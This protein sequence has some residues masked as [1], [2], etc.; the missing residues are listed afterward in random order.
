MKLLKGEIMVLKRLFQLSMVLFL[1]TGLASYSLAAFKTSRV[2]NTKGLVSTPVADL[3]TSL[4]AKLSEFDNS[5]L[6]AILSDSSTWLTNDDIKDLS[7]DLSS[8]G[9]FPLDQHELAFLTH[10]LASVSL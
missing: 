1:V 3:I 8:F 5:T 7:L 2:G 9:G 10:S 4:N 6:D